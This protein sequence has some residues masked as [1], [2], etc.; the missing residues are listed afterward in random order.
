MNSN[1][2]SKI[3]KGKKE[4]KEEYKEKKKQRPNWA[5]IPNSAHSLCAPR[6]PDA[7]VGANR[8][9][10]PV[11]PTVAR[12]TCS[13]LVC[14]P[15]ASDGLTHVTVGRYGAGPTGRQVLYEWRVCYSAGGTTLAVTPSVCL[16]RTVDILQWIPATHGL[17]AIVPWSL[18]SRP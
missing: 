12:V 15:G 18:A 14:G 2:K 17:R 8:R 7:C 5:R 10:L 9:A 16:G 4:K 1:L 13:P 6:N 3:R 11:S